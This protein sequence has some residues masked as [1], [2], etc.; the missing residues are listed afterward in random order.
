LA[1]AR[2]AAQPFQPETNGKVERTNQF[3]QTSFVPAS[4]LTHLGGAQLRLC[5]W[6]AR[7]NQ[8][9]HWTNGE[10]VEVRLTK[11]QPLLIPL[12]PELRIVERTETRVVY[13]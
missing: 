2:S 7:I 12:R 13:A 4:T 9:V 1:S 11:G 5:A 3:L 10:I 8:R 6:L